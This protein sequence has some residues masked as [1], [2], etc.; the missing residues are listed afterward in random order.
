MR[1]LKLNGSFIEPTLAL[2]GIWDFDEAG[3]ASVGGLTAGSDEVRGRVEVGL[4]GQRASGLSIRGTGF[5]DGIGA[6]DLEAYGGK[7]TVTV[8]LQRRN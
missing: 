4:N 8:P 1:Q 2:K 5:F 6:D 3:R 7:V